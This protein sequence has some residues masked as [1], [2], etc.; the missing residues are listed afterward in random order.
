M[1]TAFEAAGDVRGTDLLA[2]FVRLWREGV[3]GSLRF[4][5]GASSAGFDL[6]D[7]EIAAVFSS[8]ARFETSAILVRAGKLDAEVIERLSG[9]PGT[10]GAL[11]ALQ[12]GILTKR[13]WKW[14]EKIRAIEVLADLLAWPDGEYHFDGGA[15]PLHGEFALTVPR[16][17]LEL[18]LRS[19][20]RN[21][22][23]HQLGS[24]EVPLVR[25]ETFDEEFSTFGLTADAESVV[26]LI[27]GRATA[28]EIS[29][30][31][32]AEEFAVLKL[33]AALKTLGLLRTDAQTLSEAEVEKA[34][35]P[36]QTEPPPFQPWGPTGPLEIPALELPPL[37]SLEQM[38]LQ[39][40]ASITD[41]LREENQEWDSAEPGLETAGE[42]QPPAS[43]WEEVPVA[44]DREAPASEPLERPP[45]SPLEVPEATE[46]SGRRWGVP[47]GVIFVVLLAAV[48][49]TVFLRSRF[50][51][52]EPLPSAG[53]TRAPAPATP[54]ASPPVVVPTLAPSPPPAPTTAPRL[55]TARSRPAALVP[56]VRPSRA[57]T[58]AP[59]RRGGE[60]PAR[61]VW[62]E[63]AFRDRKRLE[64]EKKTQYAI[65]LELACEVPSLAEAWKHEAP[66]GSMWL[67][68]STHGGR[69]C[70][71]VLWGRYGSLEQARR[72]KS[73]IPAFF[74][75]P[76]N[77]P[78]IVA[79]R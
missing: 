58:P 39:K 60:D 29:E 42:G 21:L 31:A 1:K 75:T 23:E 62:L 27:D 7:G 65:Q 50:S 2:A 15:H 79:V 33:L 8:E 55:P 69:D 10:D 37:S 41:R 63:R 26:R 25:S 78:A 19:R 20:D 56:S 44:R 70:F 76:S 35:P 51:P 73:G 12:A 14:G 6:A 67:L 11:A 49:A 17:L 36:A 71:R 46:G 72:A 66:A 16:L 77:H 38:R 18:F 28:S 74:V 4:S 32:P 13:E 45:V 43:G 57:L 5:R 61:T 22:I 34:E 54:V 24:T 52:R 40:P 9:P 48:L 68:T 59:A 64:S 53:S 30:R 3:N 47:L